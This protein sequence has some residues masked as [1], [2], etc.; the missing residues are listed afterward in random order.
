MPLLQRILGNGDPGPQ[1]NSG[2]ESDSSS[3][4]STSSRRRSD[5]GS[6]AEGNDSTSQTLQSQSDGDQSSNNDPDAEAV[7]SLKLQIK[8]Q[9]Q[10]AKARAASLA[11]RALR[12]LAKNA[13]I[14]AP[15]H[16]AEAFREDVRADNTLARPGVASGSHGP[17]RRR[18]LR[19]L[20]S[21]LQGW[22]TA[23]TR[24][25]RD[26]EDSDM[27]MRHSICSII[28]DDTNM[29]LSQVD[30]QVS[31]WKRSR[32]VSVMNICQTLVA[33]YASSRSSAS[34]TLDPTLQ[35]VF[36]V[37]T[38][39]VCLPKADLDGI[40]FELVSRLFVFLGEVSYRFQVLNLARDV[41]RATSI[42][43]TALCMDALA[44]NQAVTKR[45]RLAVHSKHKDN[46]YSQLFPALMVL[47]QIHA[48]ALVRKC[49]LNGLPHFWS[50]VVRL[51]HLFEISSF[52]LQFKRALLTIIRR[53]YR[54]IVVPE[55]P[56]S[57][58]DWKDRRRQWCGIPNET[59]PARTD[60]KKRKELH[61]ALMTWD[62]ADFEGSDI[63]H[64]CDGSCCPGSDHRSKSR[65]ALVQILQHY[66]ALFGC[67]Y[68]TPLSY[69][70]IHAS[71]ALQFLKDLALDGP[72]G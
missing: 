23:V 54:Y 34:S 22:V 2:V 11:T 10:T 36:T 4:S 44:T 57:S 31:Q 70:W 63:I 27:S 62:N 69:R 72:L 46:Q 55:M 61:R 42:Q 24:F 45:F 9:K 18:R 17:A 29:R 30:A 19:L 59:L 47:C 32:V 39:M 35:K 7:A 33:C 16:K 53:S 41:L 5:S 43:A 25:F 1:S 65:H 50:S 3:S 52:R 71:R 8:R 66:I 64:L 56:A 20:V 37:H 12:R 13:I 28:L 15:K 49:L 6:E 58:K 21:Y 40:Y 38:P 51:G 26:I 48:L 67:G 60:G 14:E 68:P